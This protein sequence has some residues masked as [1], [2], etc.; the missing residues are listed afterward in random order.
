MV[1]AMLALFVEYV[2]TGRWSDVQITISIPGGILAGELIS[3][4]EFLDEWEEQT[5]L[6]RLEE[7]TGNYGSESPTLPESTPSAAAAPDYLHLRNALVLSALPARGKPSPL[8]PL[9]VR[10]E[11]VSAWSIARSNGD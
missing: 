4:R 3:A 10:L 1:D 6:H 7:L 5:V 11:A 2:E 8:G 9:R